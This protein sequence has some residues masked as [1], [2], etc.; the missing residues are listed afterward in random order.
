MTVTSDANN[1]RQMQSSNCNHEPVTL[2]NTHASSATVCC[3]C[4]SIIRH[5]A[6]TVS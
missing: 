1:N 4:I 3:V 6:Y 5:N 2:G